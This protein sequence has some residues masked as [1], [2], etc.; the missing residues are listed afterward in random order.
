MTGQFYTQHIHKGSFFSLQGCMKVKVNII[1][2]LLPFNQKKR[3]RGECYEMCQ[4]PLPDS[5]ERKPQARYE[6]FMP[7]NTHLDVRSRLRHEI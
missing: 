4:K 7:Q 5:S 3:E 2:S 6:I 1:R